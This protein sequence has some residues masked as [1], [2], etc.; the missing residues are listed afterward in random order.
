MMPKPPICI[1]RSK[2]T[3][4]NVVKIPES[5]TI[6]PVSVTALVAVKN[7]SNGDI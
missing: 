7:A 1:K 5:T 3:N 6:N 2:I 4:P